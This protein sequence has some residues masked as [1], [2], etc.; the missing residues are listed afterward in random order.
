MPYIVNYLFNHIKQKAL[1]VKKLFL[2][3]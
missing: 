3:Q 1:F 2:T